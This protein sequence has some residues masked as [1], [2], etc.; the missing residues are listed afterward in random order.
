MQKTEDFSQASKIESGTQ[1][2]SD[3]DR[4]SLMKSRAGSISLLS[5]ELQKAT[6]SGANADLP[7]GDTHPLEGDII[8]PSEGR[9]AG[10][11]SEQRQDTLAGAIGQELAASP[12]S[13]P[14]GRHRLSHHEK[15][16]SD[17]VMA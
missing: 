17:Q 8:S 16:P 5:A 13:K 4:S 1:D 12:W 3:S 10:S 2:L 9:H 11:S 14:G 15:S 7:P 6:R